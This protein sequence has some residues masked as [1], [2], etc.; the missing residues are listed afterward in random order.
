MRS[1]RYIINVFGIGLVIAGISLGIGS[2]C[3][4]WEQENA[5]MRLENTE[6]IQ[7]FS[8]D[9]ATEAVLRQKAVFSH[10]FVPDTAQLNTLGEKELLI[11][12]NHYARYGG[13]L[14]VRQGDAT[15][16][17]YELRIGTVRHFLS[18]HGAIIDNVEIIDSYPSGDGMASYRLLPALME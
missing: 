1:H 4:M 8:D 17:L 12:S 18:E 3:V 15:E 2:G 13:D 16:E 10:H 5:A 9:A 11:L 7:A 14:S 6:R